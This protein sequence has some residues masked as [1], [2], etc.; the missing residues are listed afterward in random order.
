MTEPENQTVGSDSAIAR[1]PY[2]APQLKT[3]GTF[4]ALTKTV[5]TM[6]LLKDKSG[7]GTNKTR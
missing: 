2:I 5:G 7:G 1:A 4:A 3:F 6:G